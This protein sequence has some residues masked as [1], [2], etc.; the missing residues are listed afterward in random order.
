MNLISWHCRNRVIKFTTKQCLIM[1]IL[2][3]TPDSF[4][5]GGRFFKDK[6]AQKRVEELIEEGTDIIDIGGESTRPGSKPISAQEELT[7]ILPLVKF[8][9]KLN[10]KKILVSIDTY[11]SQVLQECLAYNI[12]IANN[13]YA[14]RKIYENKIIDD[15]RYTDIVREA[16]LGIVLMHMQGTPLTM[17]LAPRYK[18]VVRE[19]K[20]FFSARF[21]YIKKK[22]IKRENVII[23][24]GIGFGKLYKHNIQIL[25]NLR[26][27]KK[28]RRPIMIGVS[29]K[30]FI[31]RMLDLDNPEDRL[32]GSL[33]VSL[34]SIL[35]GVNILR[36][37]D[38]KETKQIIEA[39]RSIYEF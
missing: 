38:V 37:H 20:D 32:F 27:F 36:V 7:R 33:G 35:N 18:N 12:H 15:E 5:D 34:A 9:D 26:K 22:G 23:D 31:G 28:F 17:Q 19:I 11:K 30:S 24:P 3:I 29:R 8:I 1:G 25:K 13:I 6:D 21:R 16:N 10:V 14:L 2:N 39:F 4:Y